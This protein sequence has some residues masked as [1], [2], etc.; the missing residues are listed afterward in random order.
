VTTRKSHRK[1]AAI[2]RGDHHAGTT[3]S[4]PNNNATKNLG[5]KPNGNLPSG[6]SRA[7][8]SGGANGRC[9]FISRY[10]FWY[11]HGADH[12]FDDLVGREAFQIGFGFKQDAVA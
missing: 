5:P 3:Q 7:E 9:S 2:I 6:C 1:R 10:S 11:F 12:L 4:K 8:I